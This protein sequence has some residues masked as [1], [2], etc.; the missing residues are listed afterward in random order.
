MRLHKIL[1]AQYNRAIKNPH[2]NLKL[3]MDDSDVTVWYYMIYGLDDFKD[4]QFIFKLTAP[5]S[6]PHKPP[7]LEFL[8]PN[9]VFGLGGSV[10]ISIGEFHSDDFKN[11]N[12]DYTYGTLN[13]HISI[14]EKDDGDYGWRPSL[15]MNGFAIQVLNGYICADQLDHGIRINVKSMDVRKKLAIKSGDYNKKNNNHILSLICTQN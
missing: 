14:K 6:F 10:C 11:I 8:T 15:G 7:K 9:G 4:G 2:P 3:G 12:L 1:Q 5:P 13:N